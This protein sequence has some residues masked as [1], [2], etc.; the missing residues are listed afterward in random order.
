MYLCDTDAYIGFLIVH[1]GTCIHTGMYYIGHCHIT[2]TLVRYQVAT[3]DTMIDLA[4]GPFVTRGA[5][6]FSGIYSKS[7]E[8][9]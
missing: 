2:V 3:A 4:V 6:S 9:F 5:K 8:E 1:T 7:E